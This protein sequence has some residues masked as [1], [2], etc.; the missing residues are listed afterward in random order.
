MKVAILSDS[1][2]VSSGYGNLARTL[3]HALKGEG[4][5]VRFISFQHSGA[6]VVFEGF[7]IYEGS[8]TQSI[9]MASE[10]ADAVIH[11]RDAFYYS[12]KWFA[13]AYQLKNVIKKPVYLWTPVQAE[14]LPNEFLQACMYD[15]DMCVAMTEW[16]KNVLMFSGVPAD[17]IFAIKPAFLPAESSNEITF[18]KKTVGS[19]G[20]IDQYRK[21]YPALIAGFSKFWLRHRDWDLYLHV[22]S[23]SGSFDLAHFAKIYGIRP[24]YPQY[25]SR[26]WGWKPEDMASM[27]SNLEVYASASIA[28]GF[29]MP[30]AE[31][32]YYTGRIVAS[33]IPN[34]REVLQGFSS[35]VWIPTK[36]I[37]PTAWSFEYV[38]DPEDVATALEKSLDLKKERKMVVSVK[39][40]A[41]QWKHLLEKS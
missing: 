30:L 33:D 38:V 17:K 23:I 22:P 5:D 19:V 15:S 31:A 6:P 8:N 27:Y 36:R 40:L 35:V 32:A 21:N 12:P 28:E 14:S 39:D 3:G 26:T 29:N 34:H 41:S 18:E 20:V 24:I 7:E 37:Y 1:P 10:D 25:M 13:H 4:F 16:G 2:N 9:Y 11:I